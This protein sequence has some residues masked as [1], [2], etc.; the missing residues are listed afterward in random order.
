MIKKF[1]NVLLGI[2]NFLII[3]FQLKSHSTK[4]YEFIDRII[5]EI[6]EGEEDT[7]TKMI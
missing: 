6:G 5:S 4:I 1:W 7:K 3:L 2:K